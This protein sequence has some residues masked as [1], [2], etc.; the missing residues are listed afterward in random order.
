MGKKRGVND[1]RE[2]LDMTTCIEGGS[3]GGKIGAGKNNCSAVIMIRICDETL[4]FR[5]F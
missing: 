3:Y 5:V 1:Q 2:G 4:E